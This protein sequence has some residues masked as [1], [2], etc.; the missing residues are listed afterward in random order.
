M[1]FAAT[2][3]GNRTYPHGMK[4]LLG[5][6]TI[7]GSV[8]FV[9]SEQRE[10]APEQEAIPNSKEREI[11]NDESPENDLAEFNLDGCAA[12]CGRTKS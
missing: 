2:I 10:A 6:A 3:R 5:S 12:A 7:H 9:L 1:V 4:G 8:C 11:D